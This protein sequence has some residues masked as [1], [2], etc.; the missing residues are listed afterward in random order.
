MGTGTQRQAALPPPPTSTAAAS[1]AAPPDLISDDV[2]A[3]PNI[4]PPPAGAGIKFGPQLGAAA[5]V[6]TGGGRGHGSHDVGGGPLNDAGRLRA[7]LIHEFGS[8]VASQPDV[9]ERLTGLCQAFSVSVSDLATVWKS[10]VLDPNYCRSRKGKERAGAVTSTVPTDKDVEWLRQVLKEKANKRFDHPTHSEHGSFNTHCTSIPTVLFHERGD[11]NWSG[12][13]SGA[14]TIQHLAT[15]LKGQSRSSIRR[16][17]VLVQGARGAQFSP[18]RPQPPTI[19]SSAST[20]ADGQID[21]VGSIPAPPS[22]ASSAFY[23]RI[24]QGEPPLPLFPV[25]DA[26]FG[27]SPARASSVIQIQLPP[28]NRTTVVATAATVGVSGRGGCRNEDAAGLSRELVREFGPDIATQPDVVERLAGLCKAFSVSA[29]DLQ[30]RWE[31]H[32]LDPRYRKSRKRQACTGADTVP[33][34]DDIQWLQNSLREEADKLFRQLV[35]QGSSAVRRKKVLIRGADS[36]MFSLPRPQHLSMSATIPASGRTRATPV[37]LGRVGTIPSTTSVASSAFAK[38][39]NAG[40]MEEML[41]DNVPLKLGSTWATAMGVEISIFPGQQMSGYRYMFD[42]ASDRGDLIDRHIENLSRVLEIYMRNETHKDRRYMDDDDEEPVEEFGDDIVG[43]DFQWRLLQAPAVQRQNKFYTAG[44][45]C[46]ND[47]SEGS[48]LAYESIMLEPCRSLGGGMKVNLSVRDLMESGTGFAFFPGQVIG[49]EGTNPSGDL[50]LATRI[51]LPP[52]QKLP[53]S[54]IRRLLRLYTQPDS[55]STE[56]RPFNMLV[57]AGP[58]SFGEDQLYQPLEEFVKVV[59]KEKPDVVIL[60]GPFVEKSNDLVGATPNGVLGGSTENIFRNILRPLLEQILRARNGIKLVLVPSTRGRESE[61]VGYPQPPIAAGL[62]ESEQRRRRAL[63]GLDFVGVTGAPLS[64]VYFL[65]N[66]VQLA[67][68][69]VVMTLSNADALAHIGGAE[70]AKN[71]TAAPMPGTRPDRIA[72]LFSYILSQRH[73]YPLSP[74]SLGTPEAP[75]CLDFERAYSGATA[76]RAHPDVLV[77]PSQLRPVVKVV[78]GCVCVNPGRLVRGSR[79]DSIGTFARFCVHPL[80]P[81]A[82][83]AELERACIEADPKKGKAAAAND[84]IGDGGDGG[85]G[86]GSVG[87]VEKGQDRTEANKSKVV[88]QKQ[89]Q[90]QQQQA[91]RTCPATM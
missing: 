65:P 86:V 41:N 56:A 69:E 40:K 85:D 72:R 77:I 87:E 23:K 25:P 58:F 66:P 26:P 80:D 44:R 16:G 47:P 6:S 21:R 74:P 60:L 52:R 91:A 9:F 81:V 29:L 8:D 20:S 38:R 55:D 12:Q 45:I 67:I 42:D 14:N 84:S 7:D 1:G 11:K 83:C 48:K 31:S 57:A 28:G 4:Q 89:Q 13:V 62:N 64:R 18:P 17:Y 30:T 36:A 50:L 70:C 46:C 51:F 88:M 10:H 37:T 5:A 61:W 71:P 49:V 33:T 22:T 34:D 43:Q 32:I 19:S 15:N 73:L 27:S 39:L 63:F 35:K 59:K 2:S 75:F 3:K 79:S 82:L 24:K 54:S 90:Q 78:D 76:L 53:D 68:N